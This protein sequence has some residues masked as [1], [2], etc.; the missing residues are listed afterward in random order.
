VSTRIATLSLAC[1]AIAASG[2]VWAQPSPLTW[3]SIE[4]ILTP[5]TYR[6]LWARKCGELGVASISVFLDDLKISGAP[7]ALVSQARVEAKRIADSVRNDEGEYVCTV[8]LFEFTE[9]NAKAAQAA[10][11]DLKKQMQ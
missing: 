11:A 7:A 6:D 8:D 3:A 2:P 4:P 5:L 1:L 10:W 9:N